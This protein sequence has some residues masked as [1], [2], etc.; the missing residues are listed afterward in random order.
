MSKI[1]SICPNWVLWHDGHLIQNLI[2]YRY[3]ESIFI[4]EQVK[5]LE[6]TFKLVKETPC[7][8]WIKRI[9]EFYFTLNKNHWVSK[10]ARKR[11]AYP[12]KKEALNSFIARKGRQLEIL[13]WQIA[14]VEQA[15][16]I[17]LD[18]R[19]DNAT[20]AQEA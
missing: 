12:T 5:V 19:E 13:N 18:M 20:K 14:R 11:Y 10:T 2:F 3:E 8:Y 4:D 9:P 1:E 7:G 16:N 15:L 17:A 6:K